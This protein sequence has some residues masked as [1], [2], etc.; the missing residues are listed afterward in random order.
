MR[1][2]FFFALIAVLMTCLATIF[3]GKSQANEA[4]YNDVKAEIVGFNCPQ[5]ITDLQILKIAK[6]QQ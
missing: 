1:N 6:S 5:E 2:D 4:C 3:F